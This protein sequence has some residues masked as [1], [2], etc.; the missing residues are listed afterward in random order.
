MN[1]QVD[2]RCIKMIAKG[3]VMI[4]WMTVHVLPHA[5]VVAVLVLDQSL[6]ESY[7]W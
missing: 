6:L 2:L 7:L 3:H 4:I 5:V 1:M